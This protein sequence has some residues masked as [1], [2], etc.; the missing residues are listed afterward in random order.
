MKTR[1]E[2]LHLAL[3]LLQEAMRHASL[4]REETATK[5]ARMVALLMMELAHQPQLKPTLDDT[6][7][8]SL[9]QLGEVMKLLWEAQLEG[10]YGRRDRIAPLAKT[11]AERLHCLSLA[12]PA[13]NDDS[14]AG[15]K[16]L[17][18]PN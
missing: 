6:A 18:L 9:N 14:F 11:A 3:G 15:L 5:S 13:E 7:L 17:S 4:G 10:I 8:T 2:T 12:L 1:L 16:P